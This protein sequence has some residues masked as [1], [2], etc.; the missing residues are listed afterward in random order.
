MIDHERKIR[1]HRRVRREILRVLTSWLPAGRIDG[2]EYVALNPRAEEGR[3]GSLLHVSLLTGRWR[4]P[5]TGDKGG[6]VISLAGYLGCSDSAAR[7][8][9]SMF[10]SLPR[11]TP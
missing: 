4:D 1:R 10:A 9:A 11:Q 7:D 8:L 2:R 3:R 5:T 6:E